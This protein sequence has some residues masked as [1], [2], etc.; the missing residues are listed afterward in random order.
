MRVH[1]AVVLPIVCGLAVT[2]LAATAQEPV[3]RNSTAPPKQFG[4]H[5]DHDGRRVADIRLRG[6]NHDGSR[7]TLEIVISAVGPDVDAIPGWTGVRGG[8]RHTAEQIEN[9]L[10]GRFAFDAKTQVE[11][12]STPLPVQWRSGRR[13]PIAQRKLGTDGR[14]DFFAVT[15]REYPLELIVE[16]DVVAGARHITEMWFDGAPR[17]RIRYDIID[18]RPRVITFETGDPLPTPGALDV[19]AKEQP[20]KQA[21]F[22]LPVADADWKARDLEGKWALF[23]K[24]VDDDD[25]KAKA[26]VAELER[27]KE[28]AF[29]EMIALNQ[30]LYDGG[31]TAAWALAKADAPQWLPVAAWLRTQEIDHG[32]SETIRLLT[33]HNPPKALAWLGKY[34]AATVIAKGEVEN[35]RLVGQPSPVIRAL[36]VLRARKV[37]P[38]EIGNALP[39]FQPA[40]VF[41]HLDAPA[42]LADFGDRKTVEPGKVYVHQVVRAIHCFAKSGRYREPWFGKVQRL[43]THK[44]MKVRQAAYL[45]YTYFADSLPAKS[46]PVDEFRKVVDDAE[47]APAI[48][49]AA[50]MAYS[51]LDHPQVYVHLHELVLDTNHPAWSALI[52][53]LYDLGNEFTLEHLKQIDKTKLNAKNAE[54]YEKYRTALQSWADDPQ[55][56][57]SVSLR[58]AV[59]RLERAAWAETTKSPLA[60]TLTPWTRRFF[61]DQPDDKFAEHLRTVRDKY[62]TPSAVPDSAAFN[63]EVRRLA[64]EILAAKSRK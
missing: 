49:E 31:V 62:E 3:L 14:I 15:P 59:T 60:K 10:T 4:Y 28:Y 46:Q 12:V 63:R 45:A 44:N 34:A 56:G 11:P 29:L 37:K 36:D 48:R 41:R 42:D 40:D 27:R 54:L 26:F 50:L 8:N 25:K 51:H 57:R 21:P 7:R 33:R 47:E 23:K 13:G 55:R 18:N 52:S 2:W 64:G 17:L 24:T 16:T 39:P 38:G 61:A 58:L 20:G 22:E 6:V 19:Q 9:I 32:E 1:R 53:R 35:P 5:D 30:P 43:T